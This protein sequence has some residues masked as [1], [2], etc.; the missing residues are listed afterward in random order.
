MLRLWCN[1]VFRVFNDKLIDEKYVKK[2]K[3]LRA[4]FLRDETQYTRFCYQHLRDILRRD[5]EWFLD[6]INAILGK[7]YEQTYRNLC[8]SDHA[9]MFCD[10]LNKQSVYEEVTDEKYLRQ[11]IY[12][13]L[14][15]YNSNAGVVPLSLVLF[16]DAINHVCRINRVISQPRG[17]ILLVGIGN[18][19][20]SVASGV[21]V[22]FR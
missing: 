12:D 17:Y 11:F 2:K 16:K 9:L 7:H 10:F 18:Y 6:Q 21:A 22:G 8:P 3:L 1:E 14:D 19:L 5:R 15:E 4:R 13:S 20:A